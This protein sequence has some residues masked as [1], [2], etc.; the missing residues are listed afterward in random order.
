MLV[1]NREVVLPGDCL[2]V[3]AEKIGASLP[4]ALSGEPVWRDPDAA[5]ESRDAAVQALAQQGVWSRGGLTSD[6]ARTMT[7]LCRGAGELSATVNA[8]AERRYRLVVTADGSD[9]VLACFVPSSNRVLIRPARPDALAEELVGELPRVPPGAGPGLSVREA[10]LKRVLGGA[11]PHREARRVVDV[12][13]L[14]RTGAG[15]FSAA[16]RDRFGR[17]RA[18]GGNV[19]TY[20]DTAAGR[21]LFSVSGTPGGERYVS[22]APARPETMVAQLRTLLDDLR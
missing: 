4:T 9:A 20:Y 10:E 13:S 14:P 19:C 18:S 2:P 7:V 21:Y 3:A 17:H 8:T 11:V 1:L 16:A 12:A 15:Q 6:F 5:R 22:V